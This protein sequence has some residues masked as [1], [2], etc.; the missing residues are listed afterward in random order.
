MSKK[1]ELGQVWRTP[2]GELWEIIDVLSYS[3]TIK[4]TTDQQRYVVV[5]E[6][7]NDLDY[8]GSP[9]K[10]GDLYRA[11]LSG[12]VFRV[13]KPLSKYGLYELTATET[14]QYWKQGDTIEQSESTLANDQLWTRVDPEEVRKHTS[15]PTTEGDALLQF[16]ATPVGEW[17]GWE[18][19]L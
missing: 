3:Y 10:V 12:T 2:D 18:F 5:A 19:Q 13:V 6:W 8:I 7:F 9:P 11:Q 17:G 16:F 15:T 14:T 1:L 4:N